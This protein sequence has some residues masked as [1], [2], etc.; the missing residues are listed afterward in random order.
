MYSGK[1][2]ILQLVAL[3]K[4]HGISQV[5]LSPGSRNAPIIRSL[6]GDPFFSCHS[7]VDERSAGFYALG[8]MQYKAE[9]AV[10]CCTSGTAALNIAPAIAEACYRQ[11]PLIVVTA[12][13]P[14]AWIG[15]MDGQT[16]PQPGMFQS[17]VK[18]SVQLPEITTVEDEWYCNRLINEALLGIDHHG[19]GPVHINIPLS[20]PL[21][22]DTADALPEVRKITRH[23]DYKP[24]RERF[25]RHK[26]R[27]ILAG[28]SDYDNRTVEALDRLANMAGCV[29]LAEH[30]SNIYP[31]PHTRSTDSLPV[32]NVDEVLHLLPQ[33]DRAPY[34]PSLLITIG[35]HIVSK[36]IKQ[37]LRGF[38][39]EEHWH[40]SPSGEVVDLYQHVTDIIEGDGRAFLEQLIGDGKAAGDD[41][42]AF[43][44]LWHAASQGIRTPEVDFSDL[45]A[46]KALL[47]A[48]PDHSFLHLANSSS[49]RL[50]QLCRIDRPLRISCNR[51]CNGID[52]CLSTAAGFAAVNEEPTFLLI[53]DLAFFYDMNGLW[54]S[55]ISKN[56][57]IL[58]NNNGGGGI[59]HSLPGHGQS[60]SA[61]PY[62]SAPHHTSAKGWAETCGFTYLQ[63]SD[64]NELDG[65][66]PAFI[67]RHGDR[68]ILL[69]VFSSIEKNTEILRNYYNNLKNR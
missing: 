41:G 60:A 1:K 67:S 3:L 49:V 22:D 52:G 50:A 39:P 43:A 12:D 46:V 37:F 62:I 21:F 20:E 68:P 17:L 42:R 30:L 9:P 28:Q 48:I 53:G 10:V 40:V 69:E 59:F 5:V 7:V 55:R 8:I 61:W 31:P 64:K 66:L 23:T 26:R 56:L 13:R 45:Y 33:D 58:L 18:K 51:G 38:Q 65:Y 24:F 36:R 11:L 32:K 63:A 29:I 47:E 27:M 2:H 54:N 34:A 19:K 6:A 35:G 14:A 16:I 57:R 44:R 4:A 15:Q 25:L